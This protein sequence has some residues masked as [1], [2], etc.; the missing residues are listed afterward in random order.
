MRKIG[1]VPI[2]TKMNEAYAYLTILI[3]RLLTGRSPF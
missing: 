2:L 3:A 1:T